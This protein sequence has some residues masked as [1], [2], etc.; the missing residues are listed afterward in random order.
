MRELLLSGAPGERPRGGAGREESSPSAPARREEAPRSRPRPLGA[1]APEHPPAAGPAGGGARQPRWQPTPA[2]LRSAA[3]L[4]GV[5]AEMPLPPAPRPLRGEGLPRSPGGRGGVLSPFPAERDT[6]R[7]P[8]F[9]AL[10][11]TPR[12]AVEVGT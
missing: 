12:L 11:L 10:P 8:L 6:A 5:T 3:G 1:S 4:A 7:H 9:P 2:G